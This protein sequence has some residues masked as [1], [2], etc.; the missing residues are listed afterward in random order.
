MTRIV[1][2]DDGPEVRRVTSI[3]LAANLLLM[4]FK[5]AVGV[6]GH[7]Q[8]LVADA[9]HSASDLVSDVAVIVGSKFWNAPPDSSHQH[10]HRRIETLISIAIGLAVIAVGVFLAYESATALFNGEE[11]HPEVSVAVAA[12]VSLLVKELL[13]RYTRGQGK[14][15]RS[16]ALEANAQH[17]RSDALSSAPV[18]VAVLLAL[19][20]P[21]CG[22]F[23]SL[24]A[25]V[26]SFLIMHS[27]Y[28]ITRPGI[29]QVAD[30]APD[31]EVCE[32]L[33]KIALAVPGVMSVHRFRARIIGSD[34]EVTLHIVVDPKLSLLAAHDLSELVER[35]LIDSG[36]NVIDALVHIDPYSKAREEQ[37]T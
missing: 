12:A 17:Q 37:A 35:R 10:G 25:L 5:F 8:A 34:L 26:V 32:R 28:E 18:L 2:K 29:H 23:D 30:G 36:E 14:K 3:G 22:F 9:V 1:P 31:E 7:S 11:S 13:F 15:L 27:G 4:I 16:L 19:A 20:F 6:V 21:Q 24:G 33:Q